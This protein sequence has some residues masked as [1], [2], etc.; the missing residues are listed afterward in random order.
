MS[1]LTTSG[2][3]LGHHGTP[4]FCWY[5]WV[6]SCYPIPREF[7]HA[8]GTVFTKKWIGAIQHTAASVRSNIVTTSPRQAALFKNNTSQRPKQASANQGGSKLPHSK[9][10]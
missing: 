10:G 1:A 3:W 2:R 8:C 6:P 5:L 7:G 9:S 4:E